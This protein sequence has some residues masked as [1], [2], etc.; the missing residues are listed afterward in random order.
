M[1]AKVFDLAESLMKAE[2]KSFDLDWPDPIPLIDYFN[3]PDFPIDAL[4]EPGREIVKVVSEVNQVDPGLPGSIYLS[5]LSA[6]LAKKGEVDLITHREP[7]NIYTCQILDSG[8]RK[9]STM[10]TLTLPIYEY[11]KE[12]QD[13]MI[14]EVRDAQCELKIKE[15]RLAKLQK[16]ASSIDDPIERK[17]FEVDAF[18]LTKEIAENPVP[19]TPTHVVDDITSEAMGDLMADNNERMALFS[20]EGGI[21]AIMAGRYNENGSNFDIYLKAHSGDPW[22]SHRVGRNAKS[23]LS[24]AL[25][26]CLAIQNDV[27]KEIGGNRQFRGRG[28]LARFLYSLCE[29][30]AGQRNRQNKGI[31]ESI[32]RQYNEHIKA[33]LDIPLNLHVF[34]LSPAAQVTWDEFYNDIEIDM[35]PGKPLEVIK[36]WGSKLPGAVAR[37]AGLLHYAKNGIDATNKPI[38]VDIVNASCAIGAYYREHTLATFGL[39]QEDPRIEAAKRI[40]EYINLHQPNTFKGRDVLRYKSAFKTMENVLPGLKVLIERGYIRVIENKAQGI[41]RPEATSY[42]VNPKINMLEKRR[43]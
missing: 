27:I 30:Q 35:Q 5:V 19:I 41:G 11:Q 38:S 15:A 17:K 3:L 42:E 33:L 37:I 40:L 36:D 13:E 24:P 26:M 10:K 31:S 6:C 34:N 4:P 1:E 28:L 29:S 14:D 20:A 9:T 8:E 32:L 7:V 22:S 2:G 18:N 16:Q 23:M 43:Q 21:F 39:M 12:R 25:S